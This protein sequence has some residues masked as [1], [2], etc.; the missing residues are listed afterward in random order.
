MGEDGL[1]KKDVRSQITEKEARIANGRVGK[2]RSFL[3]SVIGL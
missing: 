2:I 3:I 1:E